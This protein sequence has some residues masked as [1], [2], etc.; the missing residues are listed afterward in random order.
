MMKPAVFPFL[1]LLAVVCSANFTRWELGRPKSH[2]CSCGPL[3]GKVTWQGTA[4]T[5]NAGFFRPL[6]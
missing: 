4:L 6:K 3:A 2:C 5:P 1:P